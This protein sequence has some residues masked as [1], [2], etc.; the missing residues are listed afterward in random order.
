MTRLFC[1]GGASSILVG[2]GLIVPALAARAETGDTSALAVAI[3]ALAGLLV[4]C[5]AAGILFGFRRTRAV[6]IPAPVRAVVAGNILFLAFCAMET[7][8]R[9]LRQ[10]GRIFYWTTLLFAPT[11]LLLAGVLMA[12]RW[13]WW[14][15][16]AMTAA[17]TLW[18]V[19]FLA[20]IPFADLHGNDGPAPWWGRIYVAGVTLVFASISAYVFHALGR[21]EARNYFGMARNGG[22]VDGCGAGN[23]GADAAPVIAIIPPQERQA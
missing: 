17:S 20:V 9:L 3:L 7:S 22:P 4:V 12:Q 19:G 13:A 18:F 10:D 14:T 11:L 15:T 6:A 23:A 16:R 5:G 21:A 1:A 8:D 2:V